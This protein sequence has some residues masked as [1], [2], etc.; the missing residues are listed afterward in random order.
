MNKH[1]GLLGVPWL[2]VPT[3][4]TDIEIRHTSS[5]WDGTN[6]FEYYIYG[7]LKGSY[8]FVFEWPSLEAYIWEIWK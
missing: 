5:F 4:T 3:I 6:I 1:K 8:R 2:V 7:I